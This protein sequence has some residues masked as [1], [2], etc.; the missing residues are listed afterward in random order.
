MPG[1]VDYGGTW[2]CR[3]QHSYRDSVHMV[4]FKCP[5]CKKPYRGTI[6]AIAAELAPRRRLI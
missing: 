3:V 2:F 5:K 1:G 4:R 6:E